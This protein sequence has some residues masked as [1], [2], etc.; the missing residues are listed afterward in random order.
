M[1]PILEVEKPAENEAEV[2]YLYQSWLAGVLY[3]KANRFGWACVYFLNPLEGPA[4]TTA[5]PVLDLMC[6]PD[7]YF[8]HVIWLFTLLGTFYP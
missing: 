8:S 6:W 1:F 5:T 2:T 4:R 3:N 7:M